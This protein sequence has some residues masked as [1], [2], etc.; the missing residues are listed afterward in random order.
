MLD[1][2]HQTERVQDHLSKH[3]GTTPFYDDFYSGTDYLAA[4]S[5]KIKN[6]DTILLFSLDGAQFYKHKES[7]YWIYIWVLNLSSDKRYKKKHILP[8]AFIPGPNKP[9]ILI[10]SYSLVCISSAIS[11]L[12]S[13]TC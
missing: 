4:V 5:K 2:L 9:K 8:G 6:G 13:Y 12:L 11:K 3:D 7:D 10:H 1:S